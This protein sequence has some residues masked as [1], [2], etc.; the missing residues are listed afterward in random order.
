MVGVWFPNAKRVVTNPPGVEQA[1]NGSI[2]CAD[3]MWEVLHRFTPRNVGSRDA[4][5][6]A[7]GQDVGGGIVAEGRSVMGRTG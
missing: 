4:R 2:V 7:C 1:A 6:L 5:I 3:G